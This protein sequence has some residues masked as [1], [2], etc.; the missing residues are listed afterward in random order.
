[1]NNDDEFFTSLQEFRKLYTDEFISPIEI[2]VP[3]PEQ[4]AKSI[5]KSSVEVDTRIPAIQQ[6]Y[7]RVNSH[8]EI[9]HYH[10]RRLEVY[11]EE[12]IGWML[13]SEAPVKVSVPIGVI[14]KLPQ[15]NRLVPKTNSQY[16]SDLEQL[17]SVFL[18][19]VNFS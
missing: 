6:G 2:K 13:E 15:S 7:Y 1:L 3:K 16:C 4:T 12:P 11:E 14:P 19:D 18:G 9:E 17:D 5:P 8:L 10:H